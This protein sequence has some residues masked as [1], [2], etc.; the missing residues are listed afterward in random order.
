M[1]WEIRILS[2]G[3]LRRKERVC[4]LLWEGVDEGKGKEVRGESAS[5][6]FL[7]RM[8]FSIP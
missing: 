8:H 2:N 1:I 5:F 3:L 7:V 4:V 6:F